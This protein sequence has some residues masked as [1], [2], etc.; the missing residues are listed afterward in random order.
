M[1][2]QEE[3]DSI[4]RAR[5]PFMNHHH[6]AGRY[7]NQYATADVVSLDAGE[8]T[9]LL[10]GNSGELGDSDE[11]LKASEKGHKLQEKA[12][13]WSSKAHSHE[14]K[15][16]E[17]ECKAGAIHAFTNECFIKLTFHVQDI[18]RVET[19]ARAQQ[20]LPVRKKH[21]WRRS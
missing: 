3:R 13:A 7:T 1:I 10:E 5:M 19:A 20:K 11:A 2:E 4:A 18:H 6:T 8:K 17:L 9:A 16:K 15:A 12:H 14:K 21:A